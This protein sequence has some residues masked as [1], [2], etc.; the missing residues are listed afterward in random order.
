MCTVYKACVREYVDDDISK[1][2]V[3]LYGARNRMSKRIPNQMFIPPSSRLLSVQCT[4]LTYV[5]TLILAA[6]RVSRIT[7]P[8]K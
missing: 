6:A 3:R 1:G 2:P 8:E 4:D 7:W 5:H